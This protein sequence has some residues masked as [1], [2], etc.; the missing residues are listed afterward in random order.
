[1]IGILSDSVSSHPQHELSTEKPPEACPWNR[2]VE[3]F[4]LV[5]LKVSKITHKRVLFIR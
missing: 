4:V 1:L 2:S 3:E 5:Q